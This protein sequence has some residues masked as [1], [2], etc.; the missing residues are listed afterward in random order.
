MGAIEDTSSSTGVKTK[1]L[2]HVGLGM[3]KLLL[4]APKLCH[5]QWATGR[6]LG[7]PSSHCGRVTP[8]NVTVTP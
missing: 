6:R 7:G 4:E 1:F 5:C 8:V 3:F 2:Q